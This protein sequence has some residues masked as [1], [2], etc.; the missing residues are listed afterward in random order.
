MKG[1]K[2][3]SITL[4][5]L[6]ALARPG[7]ASADNT[8][9]LTADW[10]RATYSGLSLKDGSPL[11]PFVNNSVGGYRLASGFGIND[12]VAVEVAYV[13]F[14]DAYFGTVPESGNGQSCCVIGSTSDVVSADGLAVE[15]VKTF[16]LS[17]SWSIFG[18]AGG[19]LAT[20]TD[21]HTQTTERFGVMNSVSTYNHLEVTAGLGVRWYFLED[22]GAHLAL[23]YYG[24]SGSSN[25]LNG[26][27][28]H[29]LSI[30]VDYSF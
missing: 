12:T 21:N 29:T 4:L 15:G 19:M 6:L 13:S 20:S 9:Y 26:Y 7:L 23:D 5:L 10:N 17:P 11:G 8:W 2:S 22:W 3:A 28:V 30:G 27:T 16:P 25:Y 18:R 24:G 14:G 1:I